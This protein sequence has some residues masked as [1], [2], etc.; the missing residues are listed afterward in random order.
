MSA[1]NKTTI[2]ILGAIIKRNIGS[3]WERNDIENR[4]LTLRLIVHDLYSGKIR[5]TYR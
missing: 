1:A 3:C 2:S 4:K 5:Q